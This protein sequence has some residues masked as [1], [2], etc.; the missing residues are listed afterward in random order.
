MRFTKWGGLLHWH[1][2]A[3]PLGTD[4][5]GNWY[6]TREGA[7]IQRGDEPVQVQ[8]HDFVTLIPATGWYVAAFNG[9]GNQRLD[10]YID[11]STPPTV[12]GDLIEAVDLDLDVLRTRD[13]RVLLD[14]ADEFAVHQVRYGYPEHVIAA[15]QAEADRLLAEVAAGAEPFGEAGRGWVARYVASAP[16]NGR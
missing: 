16:E 10:L 13:G 4:G 1:Y 14:D 3:E 12:T 9:E 11:I 6:G 2:P 5:W 8:S 15:A 7:P